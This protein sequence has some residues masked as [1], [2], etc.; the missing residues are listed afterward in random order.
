MLVSVNLYV[1]GQAKRNEARATWNDIWKHSVWSKQETTL[2]LSQKP[3]E[4]GLEMARKETQSTYEDPGLAVGGGP[5]L[6]NK[7]PVV[8]TTFL[9][10]VATHWK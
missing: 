8:E 6:T 9:P 2:P 1:R 4:K 7:T 3:R 5:N 10:F